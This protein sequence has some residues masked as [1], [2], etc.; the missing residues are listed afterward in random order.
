MSSVSTYDLEHLTRYVKFL[1]QVIFIYIK[2]IKAVSGLKVWKRWELYSHIR[3]MIKS[4]T[5][6]FNFD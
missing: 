4:Q 3:Y 2:A 6:S 5:V 1:T